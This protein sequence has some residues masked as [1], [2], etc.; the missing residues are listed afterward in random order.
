MFTEPS[1]AHD[2]PSKIGCTSCPELYLKLLMYSWAIGSDTHSVRATIARANVRTVR[3]T[4]ASLLLL[5]LRR[6]SLRS[7]PFREL[8]LVFLVGQLDPSDPEEAHFVDRPLTVAD[9]VFRIVRARIRCGVVV[10]LDVVK[11]GS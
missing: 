3:R 5:L 9:P 6:G 1:G 2:H 10:P 7:L 11:D 4:I 8:C